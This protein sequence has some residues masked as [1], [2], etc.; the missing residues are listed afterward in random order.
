[1]KNILLTTQQNNNM[2]RFEIRKD[3]RLLQPLN[4][5]QLH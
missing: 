3:F 4:I 1:M 5:N 2:L